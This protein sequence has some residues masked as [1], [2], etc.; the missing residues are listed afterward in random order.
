MLSRIPVTG[1]GPHLVSGENLHHGLILDHVL[2]RQVVPVH[3]LG[4][5]AVLVLRSVADII[6]VTAA[7][8]EAAVAVMIHTVNQL[9][10]SL[11][12]RVGANEAVVIRPGVVVAVTTIVHLAMTMR[13]HTKIH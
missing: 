12:R 9:R 6:N 8:A 4:H 1:F 3:R 10:L 5:V 13:L 11:R 7:A 2:G